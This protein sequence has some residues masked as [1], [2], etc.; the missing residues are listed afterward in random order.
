MPARDA[1]QAELRRCLRHQCAGLPGPFRGPHHRRANPAR[2]HRTIAFALVA[3][4]GPLAFRGVFYIG[5]SG[6]P[7]P[8]PTTAPAGTTTTSPAGTTTTTAPA[9][10]P[11]TVLPPA[12]PTTT[13]GAGQGYYQQDSPNWSGY[14]LAGGPFTRVQGTFTIPTLTTGATCGEEIADWVGIDGLNASNLAKNTD[15]IQAGIGESMTNPVTGVCTAGEFWFW[16]WWEILPAPLTPVAMTM[17]QGDHVTVTIS[18]GQGGNWDIAIQDVT[19]GQ[20]FS[21]GQPYHGSGLS[22]EWIVEAPYSSAACGGIC[23]LAPFQPVTFSHLSLVGSQSALYA[24]DM[25]QNGAQVAEPTNLA[26]DTFTV[27]YTGDQGFLRRPAPPLVGR[28]P[29]GIFRHPLYQGAAARP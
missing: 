24:I 12:V 9:P 19:N 5:L 8:V 16:G 21:I 17:G 25:V 22:T 27:N 23:Q 29:E 10:V 6:S 28:A 14:A 1:L 18:K 13:T 4:S 26:G 20:N 2:V 7:H 15:L 11:T 3:R